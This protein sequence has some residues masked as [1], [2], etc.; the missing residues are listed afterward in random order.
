[1]AN[2]ETNAGGR[3]ADLLEHFDVLEGYLPGLFGFVAKELRFL[4][5]VGAL[6]GTEITT[7]DIV[8]EA[9]AVA[10]RRW[11]GRPIYMDVESWLRKLSMQVLASYVPRR[12]ERD[13]QSIDRRVP[14]ED[15]GTLDLDTEIFEFYEP[16]EEV[17]LED[18]I[19]DANVLS[20]DEL[21]AGE[22]FETWLYGLLRGLPSE[23]RESFTFHYV[24][25]RPVSEV[26]R[27]TGL[28]GAEVTE[29]SNRT[30]EYL[31]SR[32]GEYDPDLRQRAETG[33][34]R[35]DQGAIF[36]SEEMPEGYGEELR[37][38]LTLIW[39]TDEEREHPA[40][41]GQQRVQRDKES[42]SDR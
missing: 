15:M 3:T 28:S 25:G 6:E 14:K 22:E 1:V 2:D 7:R 39:Q 31:L 29:R 33:P 37:G 10:L 16:D 13:A 35:T 26:A 21:L 19:P 4:H 5:Y 36:A 23:D 8:D 11:E 18:L 34:L 40:K 42:E 12:P 30:R 38:R 24:E 9:C 27:L 32:I 20:P 41:E 17:K